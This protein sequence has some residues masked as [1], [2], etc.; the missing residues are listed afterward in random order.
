M[1]CFTSSLVWES[2]HA[3]QVKNRA[4]I[5]RPFSFLRPWFH[6]IWKKALMYNEQR[7]CYV[8][9][10]SVNRRKLFTAP[11]Y[12]VRPDINYRT[13]YSTY[14]DKNIRQIWVTVSASPPP[15][16]ARKGLAM[17]KVRCRLPDKIVSLHVEREIAASVNGYP[18]HG[19]SWE[20][21]LWGKIILVV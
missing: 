6:T 13:L 11:L 21:C 15:A 7:V 5:S 9:C 20:I 1:L 16:V 19:V 8:W 10:V 12:I 3:Q 18:R 17:T 14:M 2:W 4:N